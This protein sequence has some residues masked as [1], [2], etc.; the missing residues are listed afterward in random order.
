MKVLDLKIQRCHPAQWTWGRGAAAGVRFEALKNDP[1]QILPAR[2]V[3]LKRWACFGVQPFFWMKH[4][5]LVV[6]VVV[7][8]FQLHSFV[9]LNFRI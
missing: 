9:L 4:H 5:L 8:G 7:V 2:K 1:K 3:T 6:V